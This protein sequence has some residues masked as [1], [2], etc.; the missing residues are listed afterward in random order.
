[1]RGRALANLGRYEDAIASFDQA[2]KL[3]P[4]LHEAWYNRGLALRDLGR[5]EDVIASFQRALK[6]Q[7]ENDG[8]PGTPGTCP[9]ILERHED[10]IASLQT[11]INLSSEWRERAETDPDFDAIRQDDR[12][13]ALL[14]NS[15]GEPN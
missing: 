2:L 1:L 10:A 9:E 8:A 7:P 12:F 11:A 15:P 6:Y 13:Q 4:D 3:K 5:D 14:K